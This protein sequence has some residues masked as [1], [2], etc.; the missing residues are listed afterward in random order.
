MTTAQMIIETLGLLSAF[1]IIAWA[2][3]RVAALAFLKPTE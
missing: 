3:I 1:R 2:A